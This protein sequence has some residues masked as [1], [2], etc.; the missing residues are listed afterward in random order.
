MANK[1]FGGHVLSVLK[2]TKSMSSSKVN[3][4]PAVVDLQTNDN[5]KAT[6]YARE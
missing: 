1:T 4:Q 6:V 3:D 5:G 2:A